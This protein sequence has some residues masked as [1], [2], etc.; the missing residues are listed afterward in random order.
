MKVIEQLCDYLLA[1]GMLS[2]DDQRR[3]QDRGFCRSGEYDDWNDDWLDC[4][5]EPEEE[6]R[7]YQRRIAWEYQDAVEQQY[8]YD[9]FERRDQRR[10]GRGNRKGGRRRIKK[11]DVSRL[12]AALDR[13]LVEHE[14]LLSTLVILCQPLDPVTTWQ[15]AAVVFSRAGTERLAAVISDLFERGELEVS[16]CLDLAVFEP[17]GGGEPPR[18]MRRAVMR[19]AAGA[20]NVYAPARH[21]L[22]DESILDAYHVVLAQLAIMRALGQIATSSPRLLLRERLPNAFQ[23]RFVLV[24]LAAAILV[25]RPERSFVLSQRFVPET[26][27]VQIDLQFWSGSATLSATELRALTL[28]LAAFEMPAFTLSEIL[29]HGELTVARTELSPAIET[30]L[31]PLQIRSQRSTE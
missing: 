20:A 27:V 1:R 22:R 14:V 12:A 23:C 18:T 19:L 13:R 10:G 26:E 9:Q 30:A 3:L 24:L 16:R 7:D 28:A 5:D 21:L 11:K 8:R 2:E 31:V 17:F 29:Q 15:Q 25:Q 6:W 4:C